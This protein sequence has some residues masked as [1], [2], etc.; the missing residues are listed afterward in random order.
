MDIPNIYKVVIE[1]INEHIAKIEFAL[2]TDVL[3]FDCHID[4]FT[5]THYLNNNLD[6]IYR[7][8][9]KETLTIICNTDG[10]DALMTDEL[11]Q[12][13]RTVCHYK[14][15]DIVVPRRA[16]STGTLFCLSATNLY[17]SRRSS[18]GLYDS[19]LPC[20]AGLSVSVKHLLKNAEE[21]RK[22]NPQE[23]GW[24]ELDL[25]S[26]NG[27]Y[28]KASIEGFEERIRQVENLA[29]KYMTAYSSIKDTETIKRIAASLND[30]DRFNARNIKQMWS[31][32]NHLYIDDLRELGLTILD[33]ADTNNEMSKVK[34]SIE[35]IDGMITELRLINKSNVAVAGTKLEFELA[36]YNAKSTTVTEKKVDMA[37][38]DESYILIFGAH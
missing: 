16:F 25:L 36:Y 12:Y 10:G 14:K 24:Y 9:G 27:F 29:V 8:S 34:D 35:T 37:R 13:I 4:S 22:K 6:S 1:T 21:L 30:R 28:G 23:L 19:Q 20:S 3:Y 15:V 2:D 11:V 26:E 18:L 32:D 33:Y 38:I 7:N 31:H 17:M 5:I